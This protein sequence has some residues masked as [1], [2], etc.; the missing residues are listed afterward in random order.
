MVVQHYKEK[1]PLCVFSDNAESLIRNKWA[2]PI[3]LSKRSK[4][5]HLYN[6]DLHNG[7]ITYYENVKASIVY[8][9]EPKAQKIK[10]LLKDKVHSVAEPALIV[11]NY[12]W[13][14]VKNIGFRVWSTWI[15]LLPPS[16]LCLELNCSIFLYIFY[17]QDK[18]TQR[19][20]HFKEK[21]R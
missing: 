10:F 18:N 1:N 15:Q 7:P 6:F 13:L 3:Y 4:S 9:W 21:M 11:E 2:C 16:V 8:S 14:V 19:N 20:K 12:Y 17:L 5:F